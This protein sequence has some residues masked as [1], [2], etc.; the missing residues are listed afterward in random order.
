MLE[1]SDEYM[2]KNLFSV[3]ALWCHCWMY[4]Q[5]GE[6]KVL[7]TMIIILIIPEIASCFG[8]LNKLPYNQNEK[9]KLPKIPPF[10]K[11]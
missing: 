4:I 11:P 7:C 8:S 2:V 6:D 3:S 5:V 9:E 1:E 10:I